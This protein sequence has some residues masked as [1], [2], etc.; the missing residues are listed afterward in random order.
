M[1]IA[2]TFTYSVGTQSTS[3]KLLLSLQHNYS[4]L[5]ISDYLD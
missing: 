1:L 4:S 5:I 3:L 2:I